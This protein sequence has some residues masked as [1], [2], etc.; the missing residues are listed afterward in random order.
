MVV[1]LLFHIALLCVG[2]V[3][4]CCC[5]LGF[6]IMMILYIL[7]RGATTVWH[8]PLCVDVDEKTFEV[9][10]NIITDYWDTFDDEY[11]QPFDNS[12]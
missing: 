6:I 11:K 8:W 9:L 2:G 5:K 4:F 7:F 12:K 3:V 1:C 10:I